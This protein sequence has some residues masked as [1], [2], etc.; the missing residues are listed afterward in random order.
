M[1]ANP[2][3]SPLPA[4][5]PPGALPTGCKV[6]AEAESG[7]GWTR[8]A[9]V[10]DGETVFIVAGES[11]DA[12]FL[13]R[14]KALAN[15]VHPK[16]SP[17][18]LLTPDEGGDRI[19]TIEPVVEGQSL[20]HWLESLERS[21][22]QAEIDVVTA[23]LLDG[24]EALHRGG[25]PHLALS[26]HNVIVT[27]E[28]LVLTRALPLGSEEGE[29]L[30]RATI[31][32]DILALA[33]ILHELLSRAASSGEGS[34][35]SFRPEFVQAVTL[36][37]TGAH[38]S[39][40]P[41]V[42][43]FRQLL[44]DDVPAAEPEPPREP[45]AVASEAPA[46][47]PPPARAVRRVPWLAIGVLAVFVFGGLAL[48]GI[49]PSNISQTN[50]D[51]PQPRPVTGTA[52]PSAAIVPPPAAAPAAPSLEERIAASVDRGEL[53]QIAKAA[54]AL[55]HAV[56]TRLRALGFV[57]VV[58]REQ[59][60]WLEQRGGDRF[61]EC[62][63]CPEMVVVPAGTFRMGS[64]ATEADRQ[65]DEDDRAG[66]GGEPVEVA[67]PAPFAIARTE[68]TVGEFAVFV[69]ATGRD[70]SGGCYARIAG[71]RLFPEFSWKDPGFAQTDQHPVTC[72]SHEDALAYVAWLSART[73]G[74]YRL[75][76]E[77]EWEYAARAG[78]Q[79]RFAHGDDD[80][81]LCRHANIADATAA[82]AFAGWSAAPCDDRT[83]YTA[84]VATYEA[85]RF[86]LH[87]MHGNLWE[88]VADCQSDSLR[89][90]LP[91]DR[92]GGARPDGICRPDAPRIIRGGSWS[93][94]PSRARAAARL[95]GPP[96]TRDRIVGF[97][98]VRTLD[99]AR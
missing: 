11:G 19:C 63:D 99:L 21:P 58:G 65:E 82:Q 2:N 17:I 54:P 42:A 15:V 41:S 74:L 62:S 69:K 13:N 8:Y 80:G 98:V 51:R 49:G 71:R 60:Y 20:A 85:N 56:E 94:P 28:G 79:S 53:L 77:P 78:T 84:P 75:P 39:R 68:V 93:D 18:A 16:V 43:A 87:D 89:H 6:V 29:T 96:A 76:S 25:A 33:R 5:M 50:A 88:W 22:S 35:A 59:L 81:G 3:E 61:R 90:F 32:A 38:G 97:R 67:V 31:N 86:G 72:V 70:M 95:S 73:G 34:E 66:P 52:A 37:L 46:E 7:P 36:A 12:R 14:A 45:E 92:A 4:P 40:P 30:S 23:A 10:R 26:A 1:T 24:L 64:P 91:P 55:Q 44:F 27:D 48:I 83:T 47:M 9:G 57:R